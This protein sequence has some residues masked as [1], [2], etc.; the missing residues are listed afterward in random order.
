MNKDEKWNL[1]TR[2][3]VKFIYYFLGGPIIIVQKWA[4]LKLA[5]SLEE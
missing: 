1:Y 2:I 3:R 4:L 5:W